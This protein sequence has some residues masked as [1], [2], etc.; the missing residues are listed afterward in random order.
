MAPA[1]VYLH[2]LDEPLAHPIHGG[3]R[4]IVDHRPH[5]DVVRLEGD[6]LPVLVEL[7][8]QQP[9]LGL[10]LGVALVEPH[11]P[12]GLPEVRSDDL[13]TGIVHGVRSVRRARVAQQHAVEVTR[14]TPLYQLPV[15]DLILHEERAHERFARAPCSTPIDVRKL[16]LVS[17]SHPIER[18]HAGRHRPPWLPAQEVTFALVL[19]VVRLEQR[20]SGGPRPRRERV[21]VRRR[22]AVPNRSHGFDIQISIYFMS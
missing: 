15:L 11:P 12:A 21:Q 7:T 4:R 13:P 5:L 8:V 22:I 16:H 18:L 9:E 1:V 20:T 2:A 3:L 10:F 14:V 17:G 19:V 6:L